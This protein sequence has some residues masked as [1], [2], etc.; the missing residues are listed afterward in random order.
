MPKQVTTVVGWASSFGRRECDSA[1]VR[2]GGGE[3]GII[4]VVHR[5]GVARVGRV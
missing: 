5:L 1:S 4:G 3:I 2:G